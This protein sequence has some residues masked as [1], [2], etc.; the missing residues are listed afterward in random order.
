MKLSAVAAFCAVIGAS[1][2]LAQSTAQV[3]L[4]GNYRIEYGGATRDFELAADE[5]ALKDSAGGHRVEKTFAKDAAAALK[6][7]H[8][9]RAQ[10]PAGAG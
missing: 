6:A 10:L 9:Q 1:T 4:K 8:A 5:M 3:P 7:I 2:A